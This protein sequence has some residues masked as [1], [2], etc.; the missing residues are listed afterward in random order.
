MHNNVNCGHPMR[1]GD[2]CHRGENPQGKVRDTNV[3][4]AREKCKPEM[5]RLLSH[6]VG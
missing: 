6:Q 3:A 5:R 1:W 4:L 2:K